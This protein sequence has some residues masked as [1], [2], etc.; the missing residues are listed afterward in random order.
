MGYHSM[1][2]GTIASESM[3]QFVSMP[4]DRGMTARL[5]T[6]DGLQKQESRMQKTLN[7]TPRNAVIEKGI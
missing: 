1:Q 6:R 7:F 5:Q 4:L 3:L 2:I